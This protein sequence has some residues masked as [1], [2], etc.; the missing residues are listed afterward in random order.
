[1]KKQVDYRSIEI[2]DEDWDPIKKKFAPLG[3]EKLEFGYREMVSLENYYSKI[4]E[5]MND[6]WVCIGA[7]KG[8]QIMVKYED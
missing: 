3:P 2:L 8:G 7:K 1:M 4:K 6:G 5:Y